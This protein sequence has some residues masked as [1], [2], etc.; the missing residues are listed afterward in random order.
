MVLYIHRNRK[1]HQKG[2]AWTATLTFMQLLNSDL[3]HYTETSFMRPIS[4]WP[5]PPPPQWL[6]SEAFVRN[7]PFGRQPIRDH[8]CMLPPW[9]KLLTTYLHR[10]V[11]LWSQDHSRGRRSLRETTPRRDML[12]DHPH[13]SRYH[14]DEKLLQDYPDEKLL[15][16]TTLVNKTIVRA[17]PPHPPPNS[18]TALWWHFN[19]QPLYMMHSVLKT[20][21]GTFLQTLPELVT[22]LKGHTSSPCRCP[23]TLSVPSE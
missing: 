6:L 2:K 5:P 13:G 11:K 20:V 1:A 3:W 14:P 22:P 15:Q 21:S 17:P 23:L 8:L 12:R 16:E 18:W 9:R 19:R 7:H 4:W 10:H